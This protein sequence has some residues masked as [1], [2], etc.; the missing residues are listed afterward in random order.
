MNFGDVLADGGFGE[1]EEEDGFNPQ[2]EF[3]GLNSQ[4]IQ[5]LREKKDSVIMLIDCHKSMHK[6]NPHNGVG[7]P[8]NIHDVLKSIHN[9]IKRKIISS[10]NDKIGIVLY[11]CGSGDNFKNENSLSFKNIHVLYPLDL[12]DAGLIKLIENKFETFSKDHGWY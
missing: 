11:G 1:F 4:E 2:S 6:M 8:S 5:E 12:P 3:I 10:E 9:F 7:D